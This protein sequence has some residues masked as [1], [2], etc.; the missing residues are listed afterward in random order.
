MAECS[1]PVDCHRE[2]IAELRE[3]RKLIISLAALTYALVALVVLAS[4]YFVYRV[5]VCLRECRGNT[6][7]RR[8]ADV[9]LEDTSRVWEM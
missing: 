4:L 6:G 9:V 2:S 8:S 7:G 5:V 1:E 3:I